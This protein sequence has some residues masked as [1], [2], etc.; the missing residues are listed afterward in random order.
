MDSIATA[1]EEGHLVCIFPSGTLTPDG[2]VD[3]FRRGV[4]QVLER[5]PVDTYPMA[6]NGLWGSWFSRKDGPALKKKPRA[7]WA[8]VALSIGTAVRPEAA[9]A[10]SLH[11]RVESLWEAG[12]PP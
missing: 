6:L 7:R 8:R 4:E 2:V 11:E 12:G 5:T 1:L 3:E 9:T 10:E